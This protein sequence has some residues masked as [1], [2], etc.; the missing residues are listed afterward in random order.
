[1]NGSLKT[2][3][4]LK[5]SRAA[6]AL[7][8]NNMKVFTADSA[9]EVSECVKSLLNDGDTVSHGG[10]V[11]L[12]EC[13]IP[14]LLKSGSY[15]YLDRSA[16]GLGR[17]E[18]QEIYRK[19]FFADVYLTSTN[20]VTLNGELYNVDGNSNRVAAMLYG[21]KKV[22]VVAGYNKIVNNLDEAAAR[23]KTIAAPANCVRLGIDNYC[24]K[25]GGCVS[26]KDENAYMCSGCRSESRICRNYV[27]M[28]MQ[29]TP[30]RVNVILV[31]EALGY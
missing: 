5:I 14:E 7:E 19:T 22:I 28:S 4:D 26:L 25:A 2:I 3:V 15:T 12:S 18:I 23:V 31:R 13:K 9:A 11:T 21:P 24:A 10:S 1:M 16:P 29:N 30:G 8:A 27:V 6:K 20:A 17:D